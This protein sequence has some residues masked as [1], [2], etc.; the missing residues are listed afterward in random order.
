MAEPITLEALL[1][2]CKLLWR[3][4]DDT[5]V[6]LDAFQALLEKRGVI[7]AEE[8]AETFRRMKAEYVAT[9]QKK[10]LEAADQHYSAQL[11]ELLTVRIETEAAAIVAVLPKIVVI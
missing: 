2:L 9:V 6:S 11:L 10:I 4:S 8:F 7:S 3:R 1:E 5:L